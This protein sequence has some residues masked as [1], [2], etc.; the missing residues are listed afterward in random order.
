MGCAGGAVIDWIIG[1]NSQLIF[2][3]MLFAV[4]AVAFT[5]SGIYFTGRWFWIHV[6]YFDQV[7]QRET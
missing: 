6:T 4:T 5:N 3:V 1:L 2:V 7:D